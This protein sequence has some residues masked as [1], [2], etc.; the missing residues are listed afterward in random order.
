M[1][2]QTKLPSVWVVVDSFSNDGSFLAAKALFAA[3][4]S[5]H[6]IRQKELCAK[7]YSYKNMSAAINDGYAYA[8]RLCDQQSIGYSY[9][10]KTD[11]TPILEEHYFERLHAEMEADPTLAITCGSQRVQRGT[12][13]RTVKRLRNLSHSAFNDI[14][15]YRRDFF[16]EVG[17]YA[18]TRSPDAVSLVKAARRGWKFKIV[19]NTY[20]IK[21]RLGG[22]K[23]GLWAGNKSK[24][25]AMYELG[26]HPLLFALNSLTLTLLFRPHYQILPLTMGYLDSAIRREKKIDDDEIKEYYWRV[27][28]HEVLRE[29]L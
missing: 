3:C 13:V 16:E 27:R 12:K 26:Y 10:G 2:N 11:A 14:R 1:L 19:D 22:A 24:G 5:V 18:L 23:L 29:F 8:R 9:V 6:V 20:F 4:P 21:P 15:L 17:G 25:K 28:L 7:G